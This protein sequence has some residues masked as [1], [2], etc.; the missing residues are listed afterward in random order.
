MS[1]RELIWISIASSDIHW[2]DEAAV[3]RHHGHGL[4]DASVL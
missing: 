3:P 1:Y 2:L 4:L